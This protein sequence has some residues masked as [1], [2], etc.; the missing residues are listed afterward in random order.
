M[1]GQPDIAPPRPP[2]P[3]T[4]A[5]ALAVE[6]LTV[7]HVG[8]KA[9][10]LQDIS[11]T[12]RP[13]DRLLLIGPSGGGKSTL[14][15]CLNGIIPHSLEAHWETGRVIVGGEDTRHTPLGRLTRRVGLLFQDPETQLV[16]LEVDDE[17]AFGLEN[18]GVERAEMQRVVGSARDAVGLDPL[19]TP[20]R[21]DHLSGGAKQ[22]VCLASLV[23]LA[24]ETLVLDEPTATL[25]PQGARQVLETIASLVA[26]R[27]RSLVLIEHRIDEALPLA[28]R[29]AVLDAAGR[30][31]LEG[32]PDTVFLEHTALLDS[33]GAWTP[34][35][36]TLARL[37]DPTMTH[38]PRHA[39]EAAQLL[40]RSWPTSAP[41][42]TDT[43]A[44]T[45]DRAPLV[46]LENVSY[47][48]PSSAIPALQDVS[49]TVL[50]GEL[51]AIVGANASGKST[52]G[53][54]LAGVFTP[55][56]GRVVAAE[57][58]PRLAYVFQYPEHQF[59]TRTVRGELE[60][61]ARA[62]AL[63]AEAAARRI[64]E[65]LDRFGL[66][67]LG[68]A[69]PYTLSHGQKRRLSVATALIAEPDLL[70]LD[71]PTFGQDRRHTESLAALLRELVQAHHTAVCI[72]HDLTL[73][74]E[75]ATRV[76]ALAAGRLL[77]DGA[78]AALFDREDVME[79]CALVRPPVAEAFALARETRPDLPPLI[80]LP[81][82][83]R[84]LAPAQTP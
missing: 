43:P 41:S 81:E 42:P 48:Y 1:T 58:R 74:A 56:E 28:D 63:P 31:V 13:G 50:P 18:H 10:A 60:Y 24:P 45:L 53:L 5:P 30:L 6:Q 34:Q 8:R 23:A 3:P 4:P 47:R 84:A 75:H 78:P 52:L 46:A 32:D 37:L 83:L 39:A 68:D 11:L 77:F 54:L 22:R 7:R 73:V 27:R 51:I 64:Q 26:D 36:G 66:T 25:D 38:I 76:V 80:S 59:V 55:T 65:A 57:S 20:A 49:L 33:L 72:T 61:T 15:L 70:V 69:S 44:P 29:V 82:V 21:L 40:V 19:R 14:A 67:A 35:L 2:I 71:E 9:P 62:H 17:I 12:L 79:A 16:M